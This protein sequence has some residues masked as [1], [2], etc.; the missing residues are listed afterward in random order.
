MRKEHDLSLMTAC[1][2]KL[3]ADLTNLKSSFAQ[4]TKHCEDIQ[5]QI[6][7]THATYQK[8]KAVMKVSEVIIVTKVMLH[9]VIVRTV[10]T[11]VLLLQ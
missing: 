3:A 7:E 2:G 10:R 1:T 6:Q 8:E 11:T 9:I 5:L 4:Q